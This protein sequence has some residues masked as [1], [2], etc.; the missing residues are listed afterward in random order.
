MT[1]SKIITDADTE[2]RRKQNSSVRPAEVRD[3][4]S[5]PAEK[6]NRKE[7]PHARQIS[8]DSGKDVLNVETQAS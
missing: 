6:D 7:Y 8:G 4:Q 1:E 5:S 2:F 3:I